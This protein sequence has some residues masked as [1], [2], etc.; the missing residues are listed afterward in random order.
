[1]DGTWYRT[2][3]GHRPSAIGTLAAPSLHYEPP[4]S[5]GSFC[6]LKEGSS[7]FLSKVYLSTKRYCVTSEKAVIFVFITITFSFTFFVISSP[8]AFF[9]SNY[10]QPS[11]Q[12]A[13]VCN[14]G[15][16]TNFLYYEHSDL[17]QWFCVMWHYCENKPVLSDL[18]FW[19]WYC[20]RV[21]CSGLLYCCHWITTVVN[22]SPFFKL[23][24]M[25]Y[26]WV[27]T[28][29]LSLQSVSSTSP[30]CFPPHFDLLG[31]L[32]VFHYK[33]RWLYTLRSIVGSFTAGTFPELS[34]L[35]GQL[36]L[37]D[38]VIVPMPIVTLAIGYINWRAMHCQFYV[39][40][41]GLLTLPCL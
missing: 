19:Q 20:W 4:L 38:F 26:Q 37:P 23:W 10:S 11:T 40:K 28:A 21:K 32:W 34:Q 24:V 35:Q 30:P 18:R 9:T 13:Q 16:I 27:A 3:S 8:L 14:W 7:R 1:M 29:I 12:R 15:R 31:V 17:P 6:Y 33:K 2:V 41:L 5:C 25:T 36:P 22:W 39:C